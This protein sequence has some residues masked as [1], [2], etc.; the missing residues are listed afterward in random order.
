MGTW[1]DKVS[2]KTAPEIQVSQ[3]NIY[4]VVKLGGFCVGWVGCVQGWMGSCGTRRGH[5]AF[6]QERGHEDYSD[7]RG[8][9]GP[10]GAE[11]RVLRGSN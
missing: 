5:Q 10:A 6:G 3:T 4:H 2:T 9:R 8:H 1:T 11:D 7:H